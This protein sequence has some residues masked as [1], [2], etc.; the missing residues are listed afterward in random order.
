MCTEDWEAGVERVEGRFFQYGNSGV[1][2]QPAFHC[3]TTVFNHLYQAL[4]RVKGVATTFSLFPLSHVSQQSLTN[5][6]L[7][8]PSS[9]SPLFQVVI[10]IS[11]QGQGREQGQVPISGYCQVCVV[12]NISKAPH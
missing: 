12:H 10:S 7:S 1:R 9:F 8:T 11:I 6:H 3:M 5:S 4:V 2:V